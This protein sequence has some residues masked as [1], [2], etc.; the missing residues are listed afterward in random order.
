MRKISIINYMNLPQVEIQNISDI[1]PKIPNIQDLQRRVPNI[2]D[3]Q[4]RVPNVVQ[5]RPNPTP[6]P[7]RRRR[8]NQRRMRRPVLVDRSVTNVYPTYDSSYLDEG[9]LFY[10][11]PQIWIILLLV[12]IILVIWMK[13]K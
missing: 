8:R 7:K 3:L 2:Q 5:P 12:I 1:R 9:R 4:R 10:E 13:R 11:N 6:K